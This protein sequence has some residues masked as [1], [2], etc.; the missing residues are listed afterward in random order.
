MASPVVYFSSRL[1]QLDNITKKFLPTF[2]IG[3][4]IYMGVGK[5]TRTIM[6]TGV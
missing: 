1:S 2:K 4:S 6:E 5:E 3:W